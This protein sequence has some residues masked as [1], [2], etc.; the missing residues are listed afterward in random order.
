W[1]FLLVL[2]SGGVIA[3]T[4]GLSRFYQQLAPAPGGTYTEGIIGAFTNA[5]PIY[6]TG[7]VDTAVSRLVFSGL[8]QYDS[9][10]NLVGDIATRLESNLQASVY[11]AHLRDDVYW[12]DGEKLTADDV[13]FTYQ[14]I[15]NPDAKSPL[16]P[17]WQ[18]V[19]IEA[20][21]DKT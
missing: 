5:N 21:D 19:K 4:R 16:L 13:V 18:S 8:M 6:A 1:M 11:T 10:N 2:L 9:Y 7:P 3:Q 20:K 15:Q 17:N 12:Q 14:T